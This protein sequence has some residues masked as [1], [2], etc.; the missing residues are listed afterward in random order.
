MS[1]VR[2]GFWISQ[3][4][5]LKTMLPLAITAA[6]AGCHTTINVLKSGKW[7]CAGSDQSLQIIKQTVCQN[8]IDVKVNNFIESDVDFFIEGRHIDLSS[9]RKKISL[10]ENDSY[11]IRIDG[12]MSGKLPTLYETYID[13]VDHVVFP[14]KKFAEYYGLSSHKHLYLGH[15]QFDRE[16]QISNE[17]VINR[18]RLK[19]AKKR[20]LV[21][22]PKLKHLEKVDLI[23]IIDALRETGHT[24]VTKTR[25]KDPYADPRLLGDQYFDD[26]TTP[27]S[28]FP[29][30]TP[31]LL[32]VSDIAINFGSTAIFECI[33][34]RTPVID[35][36]VKSH[37][38]FP[39]LYDDESIKSLKR[40]SDLSIKDLSNLIR[41][42]SPEIVKPMIERYA[43]SLGLKD[44][45]IAEEILRNVL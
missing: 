43:S 4:S 27:V 44:Q 9:A 14:S 41:S 2:V 8:N 38:N 22:L 18:L 26:V 15:P 28:W 5:W 33:M 45:N 40:D 42:Q 32:Q 11:V 25:G 10:I 37:R 19:E 20:A 17:D 34:K 13:L 23:K 6:R 16:F 31:L 29:Y 35:F 12:N 39:F 7:N 3:M 24:V 30:T 36:D 21:I 1:R